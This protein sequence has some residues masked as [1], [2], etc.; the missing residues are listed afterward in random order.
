MGGRG[1]A[2]WGEA[3]AKFMAS[4]QRASD[5]AGDFGA[6][7]KRPNAPTEKRADYNFSL[8]RWLSLFAV[9]NPRRR[10]PANQIEQSSSCS[11][12]PLLHGLFMNGLAVSFGSRKS[13]SMFKTPIVIWMDH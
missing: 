11:I 5:L 13:F 7:L 2:L 8:L 3:N 9:R 12:I 4:R 6:A 1:G 10:R